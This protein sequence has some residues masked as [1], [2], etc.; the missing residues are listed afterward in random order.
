MPDVIFKKYRK[1]SKVALTNNILKNDFVKYLI[2]SANK[3]EVTDYEQLVLL[4]DFQNSSDVLSFIL[5][6]DDTSVFLSHKDPFT[7][8]NTIN[9]ELKFVYEWICCN[10]LFECTENSMYAFQ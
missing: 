10:K 1:F 4:I 7:L 3:K 8:L 9:T 2:N 6:A 5:F